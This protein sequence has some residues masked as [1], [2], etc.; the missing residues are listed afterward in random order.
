MA[1]EQAA[2]KD[3]IV[4]APAIMVGKPVVKGTRIPV[5]RVI[6]HLAH[7]PDVNDLF[8]A[9]PELT[10]D[11]VKACLQYAQVAVEAKRKRRRTAA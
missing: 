7:I 5:E 9:Y 8:Q 6:G 3:R 2:Y 1:K 11:D 4:I 10:L